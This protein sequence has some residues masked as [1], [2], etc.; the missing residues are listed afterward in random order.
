MQNDIDLADIAEMWPAWAAIE[1]LAELDSFLAG[2]DD[3]GDYENIKGMLHGTLAAMRTILV[4][5]YN[6]DRPCDPSCH[7]LDALKVW[8]VPVRSARE[9]WFIRDKLAMIVNEYDS[10]LN[11]VIYDNRAPGLV[12]ISMIEL[13]VS[14]INEVDYLIMIDTNMSIRGRLWRR[15]DSIRR[16]LNPASFVSHGIQSVSIK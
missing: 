13:L 9:A 1:G 15:I 16:A 7:S 3:Y 10:L 6:E 5:M 12:H 4:D 11:G 8:D 14:V 2:T